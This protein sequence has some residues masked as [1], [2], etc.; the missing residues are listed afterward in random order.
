VHGDLEGDDWGVEIRGEVVPAV[1][2][3]E[4]FYDPRGERLRS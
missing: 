2:Q 3:V 1:V 4:P